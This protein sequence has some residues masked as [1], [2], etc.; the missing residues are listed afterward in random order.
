[1]ILLS[2]VSTRSVATSNV[3]NDPFPPLSG[4]HAKSGNELLVPL[5]MLLHQDLQQQELL[6]HHP[7]RARV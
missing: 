4:I 1:M 5:D 7:F 3:V 6:M 2:E